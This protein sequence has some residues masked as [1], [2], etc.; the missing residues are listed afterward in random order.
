M[1]VP[2]CPGSQFHQRRLS[3][4]ALVSPDAIGPCIHE[5]VVEVC[6]LASSTRPSKLLAGI[7][8]DAKDPEVPL[9]LEL[10]IDGFAG[11]WDDADPVDDPPRILG[12]FAGDLV[13]AFEAVH[14]AALDGYSN[15]C[16]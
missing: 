5:R 9:S 2:Q 4:T 8:E 15:N 6:S 7:L 1:K 3:G 10:T 11:D 16:G 12:S 13:G 14:C